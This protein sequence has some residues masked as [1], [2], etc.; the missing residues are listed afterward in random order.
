MESLSGP[1]RQRAYETVA[2]LCSLR[3]RGYTDEQIYEK[4]HFGSVEAMHQQLTNWQ[5]PGLLLTEEHEDGEYVYLPRGD[6]QQHD[7]RPAVDAASIFEGLVEKLSVFVGRLPLRKERRQ[8]KR[9]VLT[10]AKPLL[11]PGEPG[12][13]IG[14]VEMPPNAHPN[15]HGVIHYTLDQAY[16]RVPGGATR[17]PDPEL[18]AWIAAALLRGTS[19]DQLLDALHPNPTQEIREQARVLLEGNTPSTRRDS[20]ENK[21]GQIAALIC[22]YPIR[23][24]DRVKKVSKEAQAAAWAVQMWREHG[25]EDDEIMRR[26]NQDDAYLSELKKR[27]KITKSDVRNLG[28]LGLKPY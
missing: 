21:A 28:S 2:L 9:F 25:L 17:H 8:G 15:E 5:L 24:G 22:G 20:L 16:R 14:Y 19:T 27:R 3:L 12:E 18:T 1:E 4:L 10:N 26:L 11:E 13:N 7:V 23:R 6:G